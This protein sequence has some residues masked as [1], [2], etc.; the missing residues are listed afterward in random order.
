MKP[1]NLYQQ[2]IL[3]IPDDVKREVALSYAVA[4]RIYELM[5]KAGMTQKEFAKKIGKSESE[6][7]A[8]MTGRHN[9]TL[10]TLSKVS[11][12]FGVDVVTVPKQQIG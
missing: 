6:I 10:K 5:K 8:W 2:A 12:V 9:F 1:T 4:D 3:D 11:S 7:S